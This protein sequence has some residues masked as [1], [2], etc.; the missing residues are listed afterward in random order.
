MFWDFFSKVKVA[1]LQ[2]KYSTS[3]IENTN[4]A[5]R[6]ADVS[7]ILLLYIITELLY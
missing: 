6:M 5:Q 7:A 4:N 3:C 2:Y 1:I